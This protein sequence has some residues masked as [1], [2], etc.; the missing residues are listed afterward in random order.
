MIEIRGVEPL[1]GRTVRLTLSNGLVVV[2]DLTDLLRGP[3]FDP[4]AASDEAFWAVG[5]DY[6]TLVWPGGVDLAPETIIW[7]GP[8][9]PDEAVL[10]PAPFLR[11]QPPA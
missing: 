2:R 6:G 9:P 10:H 7:D 8:T 11:P 5:V 1:P 4:I 3:L